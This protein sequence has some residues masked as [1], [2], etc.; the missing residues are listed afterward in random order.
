MLSYVKYYVD[1]DRIGNKTSYKTAEII[2]ASSTK[3]S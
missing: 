3:M 1:G 2:S